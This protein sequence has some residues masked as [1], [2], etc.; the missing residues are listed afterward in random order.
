MVATKGKGWKLAPSLV[1]LVDEIDTIAPRRD[2]TADGSIGDAAHQGRGT[3]SDHNP[4]AGFVHAV[5][6]TDDHV[7]FPT[8][9]RLVDSIVTRRDQRVGYLI[10]EGLVWRCRASKVSDKNR[11]ADRSQERDGMIPA[12]VPAIYTGPSPH[13]GHA[14]VSI[15]H[16]DRARN[17]LSRWLSPIAPTLPEDEDMALIIDARRLVEDTYK[18]A[19]RALDAD[20]ASY[21]PFLLANA[22]TPADARK[23]LNAL[24]ADL[25][26]KQ[27]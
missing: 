4:D 20:G 22:T 12:W 18:A 13:T 26:L 10:D 15:L 7:H 21:W 27:I 6:I 9:A 16:T 2:H 24:R 1:A 5:D 19:S 17:D 3:A 11:A 8:R 23:A 25:G 14:H